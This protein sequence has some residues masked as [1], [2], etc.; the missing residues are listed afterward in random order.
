MVEREGRDDGSISSR[1]VTRFDRGEW[2]PGLG[3]T[4]RN[5]VD[6]RSEYSNMRETL[7]RPMKSYAIV[8]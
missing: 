1:G 4:T 3:S 5:A 6:F 7:D 2:K 8:T